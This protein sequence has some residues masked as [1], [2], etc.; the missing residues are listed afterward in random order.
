MLASSFVGQMEWMDALARLA[1]CAVG[2]MF[3]AFNLLFPIV[4]VDMN[5]MLGSRQSV[6]DDRGW[7]A[8]A[9]EGLRLE[10]RDAAPLAQPGPAT[11]PGEGGSGDESVT[12]RFFRFGNV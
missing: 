1:E 5:D 12:S 9:A 10:A 6:L 11:G 7:K 8:H 3:S 2:E 4:T